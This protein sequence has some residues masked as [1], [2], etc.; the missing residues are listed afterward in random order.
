[1]DVV[2]TKL[3]AER[4]RELGIEF[5]DSAV[6][7]YIRA[8]A[9]GRISNKRFQTLMK[10]QNR[11]SQF[12]LYRFLKDEFAK[13]VILRMAMSGIAESGMPMITP[14][15]SWQLFLRFQQRA[16]V[17]AF[18]VLVDDYVSKVTATPGEADL[19]ALYEEGK[20]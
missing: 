10:E 2:R 20:K 7:S 14:S 17:E 18:P 12:E 5:D 9:D 6:D 4:A 1:M 16:R 13:E 15:Q 19:K 8:F 11:L 3:L